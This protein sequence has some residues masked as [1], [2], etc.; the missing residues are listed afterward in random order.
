MESYNSLQITTYTYCIE[1]W[2]YVFIIRFYLF[3]QFFHDRQVHIFLNIIV[4]TFELLYSIFHGQYRTLYLTQ[5][6]V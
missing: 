6:N 4:K 3:Q 1:Y 2:N 5:Q